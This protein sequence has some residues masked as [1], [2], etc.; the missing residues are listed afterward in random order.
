MVWNAKRRQSSK[1]K[2]GSLVQVPV[3]NLV[4]SVWETVRNTNLCGSQ[5]EERDWRC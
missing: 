3:V 5:E 4:R 1:R 2:I